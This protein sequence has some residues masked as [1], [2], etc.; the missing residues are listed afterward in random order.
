[1][2]FD[3]PKDQSSIIKVLGVGGGGSNAVNHMFNQGFKGVDFIVCN[4]DKQALDASPVPHKIQLGPSLTEG[5]GAGSIPEIGR[6]AAAE[7]IEE[8]TD[9]LSKNT[10]MVFI[11]AG[12]GG[13]TGTGAAPV[14]AKTA[15]D[16]GILTVGI[17]TVP[18]Q[19]EGRKR[20]MQA[21]E[22]LNNLRDCVDTL[23]VINNERLREISGNLTIGNAFAEAD[24]ILAT[25]AKGI[26]DVISVTGAIN[27]DFNDVNT[28]M[29]DSGVAVMGSAS[30]EG[31]NRAIEAVQAALSSPLLND[32][33]ISGATYVLLNI[34]YGSKEVLMDEISDITDYIQNEAGSTADVI[35]GHGY[36]ETLGEG[37]SVTIIA[38]GFQQAPITGFEK[39]PEK[40]VNLLEDNAKKEIKSP[41]TEAT[42]K[43]QNEYEEAKAEEPYLKNEKVEDISSEK[44]N[45]NA[46][47]WEF[48]ATLFDTAEDKLNK[49]DESETKE[50]VKRYFLEDDVEVDLESSFEG[51]SKFQ[52]LTAEEQKK[53]SEERLKRIQSYTSHLNSAEGLKELEKEPAFK[54]RHIDLGMK[55]HSK[56]DENTSRFEVSKDKD[57][58]SSLR[59]TN[60]FLH[61][62]VD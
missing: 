47:G 45:E 42:E 34:T 22:G 56:E 35:W 43:V 38:T 19:F 36:D 16:L 8:I 13:G 33:D 21:E 28:V 25:A 53:R 18:F 14:I 20:R 31:E 61:D 32:N 10:K 5:R 58:N 48:K 51:K 2:E 40:K 49:A 23:L 44:T 26:A 7:T 24:D 29:R 60:S 3:I 39:M 41:L 9:F 55:E 17:V 1:M 30:A 6:N 59:D 4:T 27:V 52:E 11:T 37:L 54:R 62:N 15:R 46:I 50:E 57:G 12:M